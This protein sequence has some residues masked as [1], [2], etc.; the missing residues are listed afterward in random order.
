MDLGCHESIVGCPK[1]FERFSLV[2][3]LQFLLRVDCVWG[4]IPGFSPGD[5]NRLAASDSG[6]TVH[7][8]SSVIG[9][10]RGIPRQLTSLLGGLGYLEGP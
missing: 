1:Q 8:R 9:A 6:T 10:E 3:I 7:G 5:K 4:R 2:M